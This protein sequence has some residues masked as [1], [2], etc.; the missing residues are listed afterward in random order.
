M[1]TLAIIPARGGSKRLPR[2]NIKPLDGLPLIAW[3]IR[4]ARASQVFVDVLVS[5]DDAEIAAVAQ[6]H[7]GKAPW[8]R[9]PEL[10]TDTAGAVDVMLHAVSQWESAQNQTVDAV[11]LLQP[12]S[13]FRRPRSLQGA[14]ETFAAASGLSVIGVSPAATHPYWCMRLTD[15]GHLA[16]FSNAEGLSLRSQ[17][18]PPVYEVNGALYLVR[19]EHLFAAQSLYTKPYLPAIIADPVEALDIDTPFDWAVAERFAPDI[20]N[21]FNNGNE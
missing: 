4:A 14:M 11:C 17:E 18:L 5:T 19:R 6:Q 10:A 12:T 13:P 1:K 7:G 2:K 9:P 15:E 3:T 8:L 20:N 21:G 16:P